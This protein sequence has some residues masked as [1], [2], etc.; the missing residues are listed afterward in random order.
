MKLAIIGCRGIPNEY[1]G[2]EQFAE[3]FAV[4]AA[5]QHVDVTVYCSGRQQYSA[6]SYQGVQLVYRHDPEGYL[7]SAGQFLYDLASIVHSRTCAYDVI[8]QLGY[9]SNAIW[10]FLYPS[11]TRILTNMDGMEWKRTKY[12][13][14]TR[15]FLKYSER[16]VV[17]HS[18]V[19][20]ADSAGI[21][22]Y[23]ERSYTRP[24]AFIPYGAH[25]VSSVSDSALSE[26]GLNK[27]SYHLCIARFEPENNL[28]MLIRGHLDCE[29]APPLILVGNT[30]TRFGKT[31]TARY[32]SEHIRFL[33]GIFDPNVINLLRA[34]CRLYFH[35]HSVGGTNPALLEAMAAS[36]RIA[37]HDNEFN[38]SVLQS[39]ALYFSQSSDISEIIRN[40]ILPAQEAVE[41]NLNKL[42]HTYNWPIQNKRL[43]DLIIQTYERG[44]N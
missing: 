27:D 4:Y 28:E 20:I 29:G 35:G 34:N 5:Q 12:N 31:L 3:Q 25:P 16:L 44:K 14:L 26:F 8:L 11:S 2:F 38:R 39:D 37:A 19:L 36:A 7:G 32:R 30:N 23:L 22:D 40:G 41:T 21:S 24:V 17:H 13:A 43:L 10:N 33:G 9:T 6:P 15:K 18:D 1:G 42:R